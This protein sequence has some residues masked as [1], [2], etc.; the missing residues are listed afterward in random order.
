MLVLIFTYA[1]PYAR[2]VKPAR[3]AAPLNISQVCRRWREV[4]LTVP[5]L[6]ASLSVYA[7]RDDL[8]YAGLMRM[9][10]ARSQ[11]YRL[12][13]NFI[14]W[15]NLDLC[16]SRACLEELMRPEIL[17]RLSDLRVSGVMEA[18]LPL[19]NLGAQA[20]SLRRLVVQTYDLCLED[21]YL[22]LSRASAAPLLAEFPVNILETPSLFFPLKG[23]L[24]GPTTHLVFSGDFYYDHFTVLGE[25]GAH[26]VSCELYLHPFSACGALTLPRVQTLTVG[27]RIVW[28]F[29]DNL[30]APCLRTLQ[31][32]MSRENRLPE[33]DDMSLSNMIRRSR[34]PLESLLMEEGSL[35]DA[36]IAEAQRLCPDLHITLAG[37]LWDYT[38]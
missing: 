4:A 27:C 33:V 37:R 2:F 8:D 29:L 10:L 31:I 11:R 12:Y 9:W 32:G 1:L 19:E 20:S 26:L 23:I 22:D 38:W 6:W 25:F 17:T 36:D 14:A 30:T 28:A 13:V 3:R 15:K 7:T 16:S 24:A 21:A 18:L 35:S 5:V 34:C